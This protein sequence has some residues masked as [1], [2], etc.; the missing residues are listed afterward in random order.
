V[1]C[2]GNTEELALRYFIAKQWQSDGLGSVGLGSVNLRGKPPNSGG[3][4][5]RYLDDREVLAVFTLVDLQGLTQVVHQPQD[6]VELKV[7]RV[8]GW[9]HA[10]LKHPRASDFFPHVCVHQTEAWILAEGG[11]LRNAPK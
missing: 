1:L 6:N 9:L 4:A 3:F 2:E 8:Q 10:Q 11:A 7:Q 5:T